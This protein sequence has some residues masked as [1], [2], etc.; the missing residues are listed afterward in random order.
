MTM[1]ADTNPD[2][3]IGSLADSL[4]ARYFAIDGEE[5]VVG[6]VGIETLAQTYGTPLYIY[7]V[8]VLRGAYQ[9]LQRALD[10]FADIFYSIKANPNPDVA[11]VFV[12]LGAGLE[13]ASLGEFERAKEAGCKPD[14]MVFAGPAKGKDELHQTLAAGLGEV[15][16]ESIEEIEHVA[17]IAKSLN[18]SVPVAV[19]VNPKAEAQGGAMRMGGK[20]TAFGF[21]EEDLLQVVTEIMNRKNL[22]LSGIH[23]FAGTQILNAEILLAQWA[24]GIKLA[25]E[26]ADMAGHALETIDLGG[27]LGVP[28][29]EG[30]LRLDLGAIR[31][32]IDELKAQKQAHPGI[33]AARVIV[34]PG[35]FLTAFAG[36]YVMQVRVS[37]VSRGERF[38]ICDGGMHHHL[39]AS[40]NLG[41][42][43]K[44]DFPIVAAGKMTKARIGAA[45]IAG[46]LCTPLDTLGRKTPLPEME[47]GDL[48]AILQSGAYGLTA[49]PIGFLSHAVAKEVLVDN[50]THREI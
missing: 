27:G 39:A 5:L 35:R 6:G 22:K 31:S 46:P 7:D 40:G 29:F 14:R 36:I 25:G 20:A 43:I 16:L 10:G 17:R 26:V 50:G 3:N 11:N 33:R 2:M 41:Q 12:E 21:D 32:G 34:E 45:T 19:R 8:G 30:D 4:V 37:K 42:A 28:Y 24:H 23:M 44:R 9:T 47:A 15:H 38:I 48:I 18:R 13:I 49:S 1:T